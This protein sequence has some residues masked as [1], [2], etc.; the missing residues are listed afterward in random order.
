MQKGQLTRTAIVEKAFDTASK[1]GFEQLSLADLAADTNLS[2]SG[3]YAH[4]KSKE[5]LQVAVLELAIGRF[6]QIVVHPA[7][8]QPRG[9]ARLRAL[10]E[11]YL[12]WIG[13]TLSQGRCIFMALSQEYRDRPGAIRDLVVASMKDWHST[14]ARVAADAIEDGQFSSEV[15]PRQ[16]AFEVV[17]IGMSFQQSY[18]L[19][20]RDD[21]ETLAR[22][23]FEALLMRACTPQGTA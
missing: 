11:G 8:R 12:E 16:I 14:L 19:L 5:A 3:L 21:S 2:K 23:A 6:A 10:F 17:G 18:K 22:R 9:T 4:F 15:D 7:L 13:G 20:G 1:V